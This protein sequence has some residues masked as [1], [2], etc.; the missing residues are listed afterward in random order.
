M[1]ISTL[2]D[3]A[4]QNG[5]TILAL[6]PVLAFVS[7]VELCAPLQARGQWD[8][9]HLVPNL[10]LTGITLATNFVLNMALLLILL[11]LDNNG[12][13]LLH[14]LGLTPL[15]RDLAAFVV[16]DFSFYICHVAMHKVPSFWR[17]HQVHHSDPALDATTTIRQHP[18]ESLI[19]YSFL[20]IATIVLG[21]SVFAFAM[22]RAWSVINGFFEH[23]NV[24]TPPWLAAPLTLI[25]SWP[26]MHRIH[27]SCVAIQTD[28]NYGNIFSVFD[29]LFGTFTPISEAAAV[30]VGLDGHYEPELQTTLNLLKM[31]YS[32]VCERSVNVSFPLSTRV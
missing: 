4:Q 7:L 20:T 19:R 31:P 21:P 5:F 3:I 28:T 15:A 22:Y 1:T 8:R 10:A 2:S 32:N 29:R 13:G 30:V 27:H 26:S 12:I 24:R 17:F 23:A 18:G 14:A 6:L 25:T 9:V 11:Y 16:L